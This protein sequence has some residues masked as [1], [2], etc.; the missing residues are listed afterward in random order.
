MSK[1]IMEVMEYMDQKYIDEAVGAA[2]QKR[3]YKPVIRCAAVAACLVLV[4]SL[5]FGYLGGWFAAPQEQIIL[6]PTR[7]G[8]GVMG[9]SMTRSFTIEEAFEAAD[10]VAWVRIGN[11]LGERSGD[12]TVHTTYYEAEIIKCYKGNPEESIVLEQ[13]G[14]SAYTIPGYPLFINGNEL[15]VFLIGGEEREY[16][17][18]NY[19]GTAYEYSYYINGSYTTVMDVVTNTDGMTYMVDRMGILSN[20]IQ[21]LAIQL[22][23]NVKLKSDLSAK[24]ADVDAVQQAILSKADAIFTLE[25]IEGLFN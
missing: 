5:G 14:S 10:V 2:P 3:S 9:Y 19:S 11:W 6:P 25:T 4:A 8:A 16:Y 13:L 15:L 20:N 7:Y 24:L 17:S 18:T 1:K 23:T 21:Q 22:Q 12:K